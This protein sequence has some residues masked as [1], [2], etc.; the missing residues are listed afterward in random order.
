MRKWGSKRATPPMSCSVS[1]V[2]R[3]WRDANVEILTALERQFDDDKKY[4]PMMLP[5]M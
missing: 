3:T 5:I 1:A 2:H 4:Q